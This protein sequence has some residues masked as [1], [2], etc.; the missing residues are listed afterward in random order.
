MREALFWLGIVLLVWGPGFSVLFCANGGD[1]K[2]LLN[3]VSA[4]E[5]SPNSLHRWWGSSLSIVLGKGSRWALSAS[6]FL[7]LFVMKLSE[8]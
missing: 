5:E 6:G 4:L 1:E 2:K 3:V 7:L 8:V